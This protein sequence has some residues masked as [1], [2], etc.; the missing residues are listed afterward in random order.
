MFIAIDESGF[1]TPI[2]QSSIS[3]SYKCPLCAAKLIR[4]M[5]MLN[6]HH[7]AHIKGSSC[8]PWYNDMSEWHRKWQSL[9]PVHFQEEVVS[10]Q[11]QYHIADICLNRAIIEF[12]HSS[13]RIEDL[14]ERIEFYSSVK[15][16]LIW[17]VDC[18]GK[19]IS[20]E[21]RY[22]DR[23]Y[24][25]LIHGSSQMTQGSILSF[26]WDH[27]KRSFMSLFNEN[28]YNLYLHVN[29]NLIIQVLENAS[30]SCGHFLGKVHSFQ[31]FL[32]ELCEFGRES[33]DFQNLDIFQGFAERTRRQYDI[34]VWR[35]R[36]RKLIQEGQHHY[37][38][39][40]QFDNLLF[41]YLNEELSFDDLRI[42][43]NISYERPSS[44]NRYYDL[45]YSPPQHRP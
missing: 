39:Q 23:I 9:F 21:T 25:D 2:E 13:I 32:Y 26:R 16:Q 40:S 15:G 31:S 29:D 33:I 8:D 34:D 3:S 42:M 17:V 4:K 27:C 20:T 1:K 41:Y 12:Q 30:Y 10:Y 36:N 35:K 38:E 45:M 24:L 22:K 5:G 44:R 18:Y 28:K 37:H 14:A 6:A 7:F 19:S 43:A 11:G